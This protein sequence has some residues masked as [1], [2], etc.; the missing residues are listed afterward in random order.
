MS[1]YVDLKPETCFYCEKPARAKIVFVPSGLY[2]VVC[3][4]HMREFA[5]N[6]TAQRPST[7][8]RFVGERA[9]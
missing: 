2:I 8:L 1:P 9:H 5:N 3:V 6:L 7:N 4:E